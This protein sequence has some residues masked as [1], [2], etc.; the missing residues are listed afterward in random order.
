[1]RQ[2]VAAAW[3]PTSV[4]LGLVLGGGAGH[5]EGAGDSVGS[6]EFGAV[7]GCQPRQ[8]GVC[9]LGGVSARFRKQTGGP[10]IRDKRV[11]WAKGPEHAG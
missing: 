10:V 1:M 5:E 2:S 9:R 11:C 3:S 7:R 6:G 8:V 4:R